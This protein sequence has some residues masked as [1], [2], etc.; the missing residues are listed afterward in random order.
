MSLFIPASLLFM[1]GKAVLSVADQSDSGILGK[2]CGIL[3]HLSEDILLDDF[4][5]IQRERA[6]KL[7]GHLHLAFINS[8][9]DS[10][11]QIKEKFKHKEGIKKSVMDFLSIEATDNKMLLAA[12]DDTCQKVL[13]VIKQP[14]NIQAVFD[15]QVQISD[16]DQFFGNLINLLIENGQKTPPENPHLVFS[17]RNKDALTD[18]VDY[19]SQEFF[20]PFFRKLYQRA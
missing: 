7:N 2:L 13:G 6:I 10:V 14:S 4:R 1:G 12:L 16:G 5:N 19:L 9:D 3:G 8:V 17:K 11:K 18:F 20:H 15:N